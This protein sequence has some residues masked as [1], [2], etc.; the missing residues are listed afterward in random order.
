AA[1][2][3]YGCACACPRALTTGRLV[4]DAAATAALSTMRLPIMSMTSSVSGTSSLTIC[5][6]FQA[7][8]SLRSS[9]SADLY[10][11]TSC[12][13]I[14]FSAPV[15]LFQPVEFVLADYFLPLGEVRQAVDYVFEVTVLFQVPVNFLQCQDR[16]LQAGVRVQ[17]KC[18]A[19]AAE[20]RQRQQRCFAAHDQVD[21]FRSGY[22]FSD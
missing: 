20:V 8:S 4:S 21:E 3:L 15:F 17:H 11:L 2:G 13:F 5:A 1:P 22:R 16:C 12:S 19:H 10:V 9:S 6:S 14:R 18:V 7:S